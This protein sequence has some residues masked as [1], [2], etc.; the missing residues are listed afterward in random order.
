MPIELINRIVM[1]QFY[2]LWILAFLCFALP[3]KAQQTCYT[4]SDSENKVYKFNLST[5][6]I[7][8]SKS[9]SSL[10]SPEASTLNLAGD[11]MYILNADQLHYIDFNSSSLSNTKV[12]GSDIS[13]QTL[14]GALGN[15]TISDFDAMSVDTAGNIWAG[16]SNNNPCL[17]VVIDPSTGMVK[18]DFFGTGIDYIQVQNQS[19]PALRFDAMAFDP[20]T[21]EMY[22]NMNGSSQN[23]DYMFN[24]NKS[25]GAMALVR[26]FNTINDVEGM[27]FDAI[28]ELYVV[29]GA[30]ATSSSIKN[31]LWHVD[32]LNGEVTKALGLW[33]GD[34]E[35]CDCVIGEPISAVKV[36]GYVF[37]DENQ[38][39]SFNNGDVGKNGYLVSLYDDVNNNGQYDS[40]TDTL[41]DSMRT[42][43]NGYYEFRLAY[44]SGTD[45]YVL[46]SDTNDLPS[47]SYYTTDNIEVATFT[48]GLQK[49]ENN[50]F[51]FAID[52]SGFFNIISGTVYADKDE[53][54]VLDSDEIGV[55]GVKVRLYQDKNC[56][57][58]FDNG[59][60]LVDSTVVGVDGEYKFLRSYDP[61]TTSG[62][63]SISKRISHSYDD[64][65]E[66]DGDM[67]RTS[68]D[69]DM[70][71]EWIGLRFQ[72]LT[73]PQGATITN[74]YIQFTADASDNG[75][76]SLRIYGEDEDDADQFSSSDD[77]ITD[78]TRTSAYKNWTPTS[79]TSNSTYNSED[80][81]TIVQEIVNRTG[82]SSGNDMAFIIKPIS[83]ERDAYSYNQS[84]SKAPLLV[85]EYQNGS[86]STT[87]DCYITMIDES[88]KPAGSYLTTDNIETAKFT[89]GG[90]HDSM[91]N[92]GLWGGSLPVEWLA[93]SGRYIGAEAQL[94]WSTAMEENNSHFVVLRSADGSD[95]EV[96]GEVAGAGFSTEINEYI[97]VDA[98][99]HAG[100]NYYKIRQV[101]FDGMSSETRVVVLERQKLNAIGMNIY[102]NPATD[103]VDV[104]WMKN[105]KEGSIVLM[106]MN[107]AV[108]QNIAMNRDQSVR[109]DLS[110]LDRG[111]YLIEIRTAQSRFTKRLLHK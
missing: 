40:A 100:V 14:T 94:K 91:N 38:D 83:G 37:F 74:A 88:T 99:P 50:N 8:A 62:T 63:A 73:I 52:S 4:I 93:F 66:D 48:A 105:T 106:D 7:I 20:L 104:D 47:S 82:W 9:L 108:L 90:N 56:N 78:R 84:S 69:L 98:A 57:G 49:D 10:S 22:A 3:T 89:S 72:G 79:W 109:F 1:K 29:T 85:I 6:S 71:E 44:T 23:Y 68:S 35:T 25:T 12:T 97:F 17:M 64:A 58:S 13:T 86:S 81:K 110:N 77:D 51:G 31:T 36:S 61:D 42:Y 102:P 5:G 32:L 95:W 18:E 87:D 80:I 103:Y 2:Y 21:N 65:E 55:S 15:K 26:Q 33:G 45:N 54:K 92:F 30:N 11:T 59:D 24:I 96:I 101:D 27:A 46:V 107:G 16:S 43:S 39:N 41:V 19:W 70:G 60:E 34:M 53:D 28:G 111:F 76:T 75:S 67:S